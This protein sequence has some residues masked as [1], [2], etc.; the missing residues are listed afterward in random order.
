MLWR[1]AFTLAFFGFLRVGEFTCSS[2][3]AESD[4]V[5]SQQDVSI[6]TEHTTFMQ[7]RIRYSK[8]DQRGV[9]SYLRIE[10]ARDLDVCPVKAMSDFLQIRPNHH[11]PLLVH[12]NGEP[13]TSYHCNHIL[14]QGIVLI[15][16]PPE[17]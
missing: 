8:T 11:G 15:G 2:K 17:R 6:K 7:L 4:R 1:A 13:L 12:F 9:T 16:L 3:K 5:L 10:S 14:K